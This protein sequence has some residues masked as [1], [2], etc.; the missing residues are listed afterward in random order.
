MVTTRSLKSSFVFMQIPVTI[1]NIQVDCPSGK[2][3][4]RG[5]GYIEALR[6]FVPML[7]LMTFSI[8]WA[9][10]SPTDMVNRRPR[11][12]LYCLV[13]VASNV[14]CELILAQMS[15]SRAPVYNWLVLLYS[16]VV[17]GLCLNRH[18]LWIARMELSCLV[19]LSCYVTLKH[20]IYAVNL[21]SE[22]ANTLDVPVFR[23]KPVH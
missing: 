8:A 9:V 1:H 23:V 12:F 19:L 22:I 11:L 7:T 2:R 4:H 13:T 3:W 15:K 17:C 6:P 21:V 18:T 10:F 14:C 16:L 5:M 20:L